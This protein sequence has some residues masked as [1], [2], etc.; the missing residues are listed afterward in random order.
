MK[1]VEQL[2]SCFVKLPLENQTIA[3][4][5]ILKYG[6]EKGSVIRWHILSEEEQITECPMEREHM[7]MSDVEIIWEG[8]LIISSHL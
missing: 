2:Y 7:S 1:Y 8:S 3:T 4:E 6:P 5:F